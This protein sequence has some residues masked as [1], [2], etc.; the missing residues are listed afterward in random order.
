MM[1]KLLVSLLLLSAAAVLWAD[2]SSTRRTRIALMEN[3]ITRAVTHAQAPTWQA[4][5]RL[6]QTQFKR[7][8]FKAE[9]QQPL[10]S[11]LMTVLSYRDEQTY[12]RRTLQVQKSMQ[13]NP[14]LK[15]YTFAAPVPADLVRLSQANYAA[16]HAFLKN[17]RGAAVI[18][19]Q[20]VRPFTLA[21]QIKGT[22]HGRLELWLDEPTKKVYLM[23]DNFYLTSAEKYGLHLK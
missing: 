2:G 7:V 4:Q 9:T 6:I 22:P 5:L 13:A 23:S 1:K 12:L 15:G 14:A 20:R 17:L 8:P 11:T 19:T 18:K 3:D 10:P 21:V 16:L